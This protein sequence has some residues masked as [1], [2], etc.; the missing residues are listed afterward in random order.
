M[1]NARARVCV[2]LCVRVRV[3]ARLSMTVQHLNHIFKKPRK[4]PCISRL[5]TANNCGENLELA[6]DILQIS[7]QC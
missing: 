1:H 3:R 7:R 6:S 2:C 5:M 4:P